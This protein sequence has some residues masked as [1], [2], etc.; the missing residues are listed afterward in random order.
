MED[1][2]YLAHLESDLV[3]RGGSVTVSTSGKVTELTL[4]RY[5]GVDLEHPTTIRTSNQAFVAYL[6]S[7]AKSGLAIWPEGPPVEAA[8]SLFEIHLDEEM[9]TLAGNPDTIDIT[10]RGMKPHR[11]RPRV[12]EPLPPG[13]Y[14]WHA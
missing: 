3:S 5:E 12:E 1:E 2:D 4:T 13:E 7:M 11:S 10:R 9:T 6:R 14:E 8:Y